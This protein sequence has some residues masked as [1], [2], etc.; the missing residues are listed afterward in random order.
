[1]NASKHQNEADL[2][3]QIEQQESAMGD[4]LLRVMER[5]LAPLQQSVAALQQQFEQLQQNTS[6]TVQ[7]LAGTLGEHMADETGKI[8]ST[9]RPL[10][11]SINDMANQLDDLRNQLTVLERAHSTFQD[12]SCVQHQQATTQLAEGL[13]LLGSQLEQG[14][15]STTAQLA[16]L[17]PRFDDLAGGVE[18]TGQRLSA[19]L[20]QQ[21]GYQSALIAASVQQELASQL[22]PLRRRSSWSLAL[23]AGCCATTLVLLVLQLLH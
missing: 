18:Q 8:K 9:I 20:E 16:T 13:G 5:P 1:M 15:H 17:P 11:K 14:Q 10:N 3:H 23:A 19:Q 6:R 22:T 4:L 2:Q 7:S 21:L 12:T